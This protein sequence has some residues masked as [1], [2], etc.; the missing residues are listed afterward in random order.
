MNSLHFS[1][2]AFPGFDFEHNEND[3]NFRYVFTIAE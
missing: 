1:A 3:N 2:E